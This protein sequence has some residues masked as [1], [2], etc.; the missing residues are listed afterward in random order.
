MATSPSKTAIDWRTI[1]VLVF[2]AANTFLLYT[3]HSTLD[4]D[5]LAVQAAAAQ[6]ASSCAV[7]AQSAP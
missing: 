4:K 1:L 5:I 7:A 6:A 3:G 2:I